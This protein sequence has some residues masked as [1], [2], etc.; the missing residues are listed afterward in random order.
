MASQLPDA[1]AG[2]S[3]IR[4]CGHG[5]RVRVGEGGCGWVRVGVRVGE[6]CGRDGGRGV[7]WAGRCNLCGCVKASR[8]GPAV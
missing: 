2:F 6:V 4:I 3:H 8:V 5:W 7:L 1:V